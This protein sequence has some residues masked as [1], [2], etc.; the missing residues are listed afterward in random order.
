MNATIITIKLNS[1]I[2]H[3]GE[4]TDHKEGSRTELNTILAYLRIS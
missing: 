1:F 4:E 3:I 2:F